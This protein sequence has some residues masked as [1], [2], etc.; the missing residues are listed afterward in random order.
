MSSSGE[1]EQARADVGPSATDAPADGAA[2]RL[3]W[4]SELDSALT[5]I[6]SRL[7]HPR[8]RASDVAAQPTL[9]QL[10]QFDVTNELL[11]EIAWRVSEQLKRTQGGAAGT[12]LAAA[13]PVPVAPPQQALP[14]GVAIVIRLRRPLFSWKFWRRRSRRRQALINFSDLRVT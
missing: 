11:D 1:D 12:P 6:D 10:G 13:A 5:D 2:Q 3:E 4:Q 9:P 14:D 7:R 8:R